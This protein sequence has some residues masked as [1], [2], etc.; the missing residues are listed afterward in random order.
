M[1]FQRGKNTKNPSTESIKDSD[2]NDFWGPLLH[3]LK[4]PQLITHDKCSK[5]IFLILPVSEVVD[6]LSRRHSGKLQIDMQ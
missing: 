5:A 2:R 1:R 4:D 3:D 6:V